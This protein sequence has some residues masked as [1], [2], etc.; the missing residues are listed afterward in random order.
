MN[1]TTHPTIYIHQKLSEGVFVCKSGEKSSMSRKIKEQ[2]ATK[3]KNT[4]I[5]YSS[6]VRELSQLDST[7]EGRTTAGC[8]ASTCAPLPLTTTAANWSREE[9][10]PA[11]LGTGTDNA[12]QYSDNR[13]ALRGKTHFVKIQRTVPT[14]RWVPGDSP[15]LH[16]KWVSRKN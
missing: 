7:K 13:H 9:T 15:L 2:S 3:L 11:T 12:G 8:H 4:I 14:A 1:V 10:A 16:K 6:A 5:F